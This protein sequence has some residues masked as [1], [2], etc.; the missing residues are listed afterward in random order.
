MQKNRADLP[1]GAD[2]AA[3]AEEPVLSRL[4]LGFQ[5][6]HGFGHDG[7]E[8]GLFSNGEVGEHFAVEV[9]PRRFDALP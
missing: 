9:D 7:L 8:R 4:G 2:K 5:G 1:A 3:R 6:I